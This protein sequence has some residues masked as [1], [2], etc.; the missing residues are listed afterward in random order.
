[1]VNDGEVRSCDVC[2]IVTDA[3]DGP[4]WPHGTCE[5]CGP[6]ERVASYL[7]LEAVDVR[8]AVRERVAVLVAAAARTDS[9]VL[10]ARWLDE[11]RTLAAAV[12]R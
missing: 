9:D 3:G 11:A 5:R 10:R 4:D 7:G 2:G 6:V 8:A 1:M 12:S